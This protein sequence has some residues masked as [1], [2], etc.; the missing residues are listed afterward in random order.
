MAKKTVLLDD[1]DSNVEATETVLFSIEGE[2]FELD[3][4]EKNA[5]SLRTALGKYTKAGRPV[6]VRDAVKQLT[7]NGDYDPAIVRAWLVAKGRQVSEKGRVP[8]ELVSEW[9]AAGRPTTTQQ[10]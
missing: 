6:A 1:L 9:V 8:A 4:S 2:F 5:T 7:T 3:L 10:S